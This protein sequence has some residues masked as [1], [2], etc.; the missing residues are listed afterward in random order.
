MLNKF[1]VTIIILSKELRYSE[2][3]DYI[4]KLKGIYVWKNVRQINQRWD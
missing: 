1:D 4:K 3:E 2:T